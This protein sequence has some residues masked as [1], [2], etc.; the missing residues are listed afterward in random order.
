MYGLGIRDVEKITI[1]LSK[2]KNILQNNKN[3]VPGRNVE[4]DERTCLP[5]ERP[6]STHAWM[7][8]TEFAR[9]QALSPYVIVLFWACT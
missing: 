7:G 2:E 1:I 5:I 9:A 4:V 3:T 8:R 6:G